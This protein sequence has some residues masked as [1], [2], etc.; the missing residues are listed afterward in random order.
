[1]TPLTRVYARY[2]PARLVW[3]AVTLTYATALALLV[4]FGEP[5]G[6]DIVYIDLN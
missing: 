3:L 4:L 2:L 5:V 6:D 1:M